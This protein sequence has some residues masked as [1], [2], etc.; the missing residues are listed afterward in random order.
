MRLK[1]SLFQT[2]SFITK[3]S[4]IDKIIFIIGLVF[5]IFSIKLTISKMLFLN[6]A[7]KFPATVTELVLKK[8]SNDNSFHYLP[9]FLYVKKD[10]TSALF[11]ST[12]ASCPPSF[13]IGE[14][15]HL[16]I[17][18]NEEDIIEDQFFALYGLEMTLFFISFISLAIFIRKKSISKNKTYNR[19]LTKSTKNLTKNR[20]YRHTVLDLS[21]KKIRGFSTRELKRLIQTTH[22]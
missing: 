3:S 19:Y 13:Q 1:F 22:C 16:Y 10:G 9:I 12:I 11:T 14:Q 21:G 8:S 15:T 20:N 6:S 2:T 18:P 17:S 5:F 4:F 7:E